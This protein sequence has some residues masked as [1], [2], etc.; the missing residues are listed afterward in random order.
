MSPSAPAN[1]SSWKNRNLSEFLETVAGQLANPASIAVVEMDAA[2]RSQTR[3][4]RALAIGGELAQLLA[5]K[6]LHP[7]D[8]LLCRIPQQQVAVLRPCRYR[9]RLQK[10]RTYRGGAR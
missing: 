9:G 4:H 3:N 2:R 7:A 8:G 6:M 1:P 10:H 5:G